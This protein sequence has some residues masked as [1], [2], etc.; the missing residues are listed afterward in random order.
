MLPVTGS[1][2]AF[3]AWWGMKRVLM[4]FTPEAL[5]LQ[6][7]QTKRVIRWNTLKDVATHKGI[8]PPMVYFVYGGSGALV[9]PPSHAA[10]RAITR[11]CQIHR[12]EALRYTQ[13]NS[14]QSATNPN[15]I[16]MLH[17]DNDLTN[18]I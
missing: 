4:I 12:D 18:S 1:L 14:M 6:I 10:A 7:G 9:T 13:Q 16:G 11:L 17:N 8:W 15:R 3:I 5:L 2:A